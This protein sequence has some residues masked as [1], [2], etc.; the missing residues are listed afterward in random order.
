MKNLLRTILGM[1]VIIVC[2]K[3]FVLLFFICYVRFYD[4]NIH[5]HLEKPA[6]VETIKDFSK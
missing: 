2:I 4:Y 5:L 1:L 3:I 6:Q